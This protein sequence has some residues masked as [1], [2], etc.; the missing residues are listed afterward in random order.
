M[1]TIDLA[2]FC[3]KDDVREYMH[4]PFAVLGGTGATN[5]HILAWVADASVGKPLRKPLGPRESESIERL[6]VRAKA[7]AVD[8]EAQWIA[9][10]TIRTSSRKCAQ[11]EGTGVVQVIEC[12]D[13]DGDGYFQHGS[14]DYD[15]KE[16][17]GVGHKNTTGIGEQCDECG[18]SGESEVGQPSSFGVLHQFD[19]RG[20]TVQSHFISR[21]RKLPGC[22]I[23][24]YD[25]YQNTGLTFV[26]N[27]GVG[28]VMP[29]MKNPIEAEA[30]A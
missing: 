16:C 20:F 29:C 13:C 23:K 10:D 11:C 9:V 28:I 7:D 4:A 15:C 3:G 27:G 17:N 22:K 25:S 2:P 8:P 1:S 18:G 6:I 14:H 12:E 26:F 19:G 21:M 5:G 24:R 30:Q